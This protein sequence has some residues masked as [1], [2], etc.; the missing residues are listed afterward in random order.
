MQTE[1]TWDYLILEGIAITPSFMREIEKNF[2]DREVELIILA[3]IDEDRIKKRISSRGLWGP[4]DTYPNSLIPKEVEW[5]M[6]Y[7]HWFIDQARK[8]NINVKYN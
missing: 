8:F 6:L 2:S 5:V 3:D 4:L 7:N 1:I